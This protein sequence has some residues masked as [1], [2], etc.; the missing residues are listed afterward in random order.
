MAFGD[1][2]CSFSVSGLFRSQAPAAFL[3]RAEGVGFG[4][5][6]RRGLREIGGVVD[7]V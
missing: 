2:G 1:G 4:A 5:G 7:G 6:E 3:W